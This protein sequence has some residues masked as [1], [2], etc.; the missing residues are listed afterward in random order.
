VAKL[1]DEP[2]AQR[3]FG[4]WSMGHA[5]IASTELGELAPLRAFLDPAFRY[6]HCNEPMARALIAAFTTGRWRRAI[7]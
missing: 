1:I 4:D 3:G 6:W 7:R 2:I 5:R